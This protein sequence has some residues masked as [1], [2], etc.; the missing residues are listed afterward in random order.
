[1]RLRL[2]DGEW[3]KSGAGEAMSGFKNIAGMRYGR[4]TAICFHSRV[5]GI[6]RWECICDCGAKAIVLIGHLRTGHTTSCGCAHKEQLSARSQTHGMSHV[7]EY[8]VRV[9][10][11]QRCTNPHDKRWSD[12]GGRGITV[13]QRWADS[14]ENFLSDMGRRPGLSWTIERIDNDGPYSPENC[15][16]ATQLEQARNRRRRLVFPMHGNNGKFIR[17]TA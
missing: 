11:I 14:F 13:C 15:K 5:N 7:P 1:M 2:H 10:L 16:W 3:R 4:L 9:A 12:Y 6:T 8:W 17:A